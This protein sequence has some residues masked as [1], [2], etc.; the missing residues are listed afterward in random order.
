MI[1]GYEFGAFEH[2]RTWESETK[3]K[4]IENSPK[5]VKAIY[6]RLFEKLKQKPEKLIIQ[7]IGPV[8]AG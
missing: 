3:L 5:V 1:H 4:W 6:D 2:A 8:M 7:F